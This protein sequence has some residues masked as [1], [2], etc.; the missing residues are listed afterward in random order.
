L[1]REDAC[2]QLRRSLVC[3]AVADSDSVFFELQVVIHNSG[4]VLVLVLVLVL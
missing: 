4:G 3:E 2:L 1:G